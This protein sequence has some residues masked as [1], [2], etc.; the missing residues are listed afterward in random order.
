MI[1][2]KPT[3]GRY[4]I[5]QLQ[6]LAD[7][8]K[9]RTGLYYPFSRLEELGLKIQPALQIL[10]IDVFSE[11]IDLAPLLNE[12]WPDSV[13]QALISGLTVRETQFFR[14][15]GM[16]KYLEE[17]LSK[18]VLALRSSDTM[19]PYRIW[20]T[21]CCTGEEP[22]S[23]SI[24]LDGLAKKYQR[25]IN[26]AFEIIATDISDDYLE[27]AAAGVYSKWSLRS[28]EP[29]LVARNFKELDSAQ[30]AI[31]SYLKD[32]VK[33]RLFN[34]K[35]T[36]FDTEPIMQR[37]FDLILCR[38]VLIYFHQADAAEVLKILV[39]RLNPGGELIVSTFDT[40]NCHI[41][42]TRINRYSDFIAISRAPESSLATPAHK[43]RSGV[44]TN[45]DKLPPLMQNIKANQAKLNA[46]VRK[47]VK[48]GNRE[49]ALCLLERMVTT[50]PLSPS[51]FYFK[52]GLLIESNNHEA[53]LESL[54]QA[55]TI[56]PRYTIAY[57]ALYSLCR[58]LSR[59]AA[60]QAYLDIVRNLLLVCPA[61]D[62]LEDGEGL[63]VGQL[64][65]I[66]Q[67]LEKAGQ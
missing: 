23:I 11:L 1:H 60:A 7:I 13:L 61:T 35:E 56:N 59:P 54:E 51:L 57:F 9:C 30:F 32:T 44:S 52:A 4:N 18:T 45:P 14:A 39:E 31:N 40:W 66:L 10:G 41:P 17:E 37:K 42:G 3:V 65:V 6:L 67:T 24:M 62:L 16:W 26:S 28:C 33:F 58:K 19:K 36:D 55:I 50:E 2:Q 49:E 38:N 21:A 27:R 25:P 63:T 29:Q 64:L 53:A 20:S 22:Y 15:K 43:N 5:Q 46:E 48:V 47:L 12:P 8:L 34:L